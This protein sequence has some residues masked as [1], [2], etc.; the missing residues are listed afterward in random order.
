MRN[1]LIA[2][3]TAATIAFAAGAA[4]AAQSTVEI[5]R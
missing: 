5:F 1:T 2:V 3:M 4:Q